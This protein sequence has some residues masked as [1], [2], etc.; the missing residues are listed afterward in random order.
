MPERRQ[1][2]GDIV[3][4]AGAVALVAAA[5]VLITLALSGGE[6]GVSEADPAAD[7]DLVE[8]TGA[9]D[10]SAACP[11][12]PTS[13][14]VADDEDNTLRI[15]GT[16]GGGPL[17]RLA[18]GEHLGVVEGAA[19]PE[20]DIEGA[21]L[22]G[23]TCFWISSHGRNRKGKWRP[24]RHRLFGTSLT[25]DGAGA[26][27]LPVGTHHADLVRALAAVQTGGAALAEAV[28]PA[29]ERVPS[30]APKDRGLNIEG[31]SATPDGG[32]LL[33]ALRNPRIDGKAALV[34]LL[35]PEEVLTSGAAPRLGPVV[36]L[37]LVGPS[38]GPAGGLG[39]RSLEYSARHGGY[40]LVAGPHDG[41]PGFALFLWSGVSDAPPR[42]LPRATEQINSI[43]GF[44]PEAIV[45]FPEAER[46]L[47]LSDDG[48]RWQAVDSAADCVEGG[49][50]GGRCR[51]KDLLD[52]DRRRFRGLWIDVERAG[53]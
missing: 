9:S 35:N 38:G 42:L 1:W 2:G 32:S 50:E 19:H 8:F 4:V 26:G 13:F 27:L 12:G 28:G 52:P 11:I 25:V 7:D 18:W 22:L 43:D 5:L 47:L 6:T 36:L 24:G 3:R 23:G 41:G 31:L 44:A 21:T 20:V 49:F 33:V 30:L 40:L 14:V 16:E 15:Y 10:A 46:L 45:V 34:P 29:D 53:P 39:V 17:L 48:S 51:A 37:R